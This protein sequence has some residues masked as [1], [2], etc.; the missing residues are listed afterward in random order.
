MAYPVEM[1]R[2]IGKASFVPYL[3]MLPFGVFLASTYVALQS[4]SARKKRFALIAKTQLSQA[5]GG[6]GMQLVAGATSPAPFGLIFGH[7]LFGGSEFLDCSE[8]F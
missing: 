5:V 6:T 4:W 8:V 1:A 2:M 3:W 7:M